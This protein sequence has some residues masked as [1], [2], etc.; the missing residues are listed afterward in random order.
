M[1]KAKSNTAPKLVLICEPHPHDVLCARGNFAN[2]HCGN[3]YYHDL[4]KKNERDCALAP[5]KEKR[6]FAKQIV[7]D[8]RRRS[9]SGRFLKQDCNTKAWYEIDDKEI[10]KKVRQALRE[11]EPKIRKLYQTPAGEE[12]GEAPNEDDDNHMRLPDDIP[13]RL[14]LSPD[15]KNQPDECFPDDPFPFAVPFDDDPYPFAIPLDNFFP[16]DVGQPVPK[17]RRPNGLSVGF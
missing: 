6:I 8:I 5:K 2:N 11:N 12:E 4:I 16:D 7:D 13:V 10:W 17:K 15:N 14:P 9:P 1:N 3:K